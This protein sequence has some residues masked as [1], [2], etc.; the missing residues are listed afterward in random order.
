[1]I[2]RIAP[3]RRPQGK[4]DG[5]QRWESLLFCHWEIPAAVLRELVPAELEIDTFDGSAFVATV[6]FKMREIRPNWLPRS[7]AFNFFETNVRTYVVHRG[8]PGVYFFSLDASSRL[9]VW[10]A[11]T[12]WALPYYYAQMS[13]ARNDALGQ[14]SYQSRRP[15]NKDGL[16]S[17]HVTFRV[18]NEIG[19][20]KPDTLE[21]FLFERY[22]LFVKR[23]SK[24]HVGT[25]HHKPYSVHAATVDTMED[26]LLEAAAIKG[27]TS[28]PPLVHYSPGVD[29]EVFAISPVE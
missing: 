25:V 20:S 7:L 15:A 28:P 12:G 9:A 4:N 29:V 22:L 3:T 13:F 10:A 16:G 1:M 17:H 2:D 6:P 21:H 14:M 24:I 19:E 11:R 5:T 18:G 26:R 8:R 27:I 23:N